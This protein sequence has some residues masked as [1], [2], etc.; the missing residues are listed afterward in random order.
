MSQNLRNRRIA[1]AQFH[2]RP[3]YLALVLGLDEPLELDHV[4]TPPEP[5]VLAPYR[6]MLDV[7]EFLGIS[8]A[9]VV[10]QAD[11]LRPAYPEWHIRLADGSYFDL[12][13]D[14]VIKSPEQAAY[15]LRDRHNASR[16][17]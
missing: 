16:A 15:T 2:P 4:P 11:M 14:L 7:L 12:P 3:C 13:Y 8:G 17:A 6:R 9:Q 1:L 5:A 10:L